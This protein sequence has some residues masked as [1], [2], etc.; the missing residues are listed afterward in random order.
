MKYLFASDVH[1]S[2]KYAALLF[3]AFEREKADK[4][5]FLGDIMYHGPRNP[6]PEEYAPARVAEIFNAHKESVLAV[7]G[8]C[9]ADVDQM[10]L[11]FPICAKHLLLDLSGKC[12]FVTHGDEF[13]LANLPHLASG[14]VLINGHFHTCALEKHEN[15]FYVNPGSVSLPKDGFR[16]YVIFEEGVFTLK[17]LAGEEKQTLKI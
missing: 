14:G 1:G 17:T 2:A 6:L 5:V 3:E 7:R 15:F 4:L 8:N 10:L 13:S 12:A 11:E 9:D 16:G